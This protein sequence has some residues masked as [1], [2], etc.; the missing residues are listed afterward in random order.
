MY[1][2]LT[3]RHLHAVVG[4]SVGLMGREILSEVVSA[5]PAYS[6]YIKRR[7]DGMRL[8]DCGRRPEGESTT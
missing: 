4:R 3:V 6:R 1:A 8:T 5:F 7:V 2:D